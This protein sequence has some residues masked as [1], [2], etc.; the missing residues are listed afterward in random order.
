M[1][2]STRP[3][4]D[5]EPILDLI[6]TALGQE[7]LSGLCEMLEGIARV[8]DAYGCI[9]WQETPPTGPS[10]DHLFVL[11]HWF[12]DN[13]IFATHD[14]PIEG[15]ATGEAVRTSRTRN[16][17]DVHKGRIFWDRFMKETGIQAFCSIPIDFVDGA[18][19][20]VNLYRKEAQAFSASEIVQLERLAFLVPRLYQTILDRV[21]FN[22][23]SKVT[24]ISHAADLRV[25]R[26]ALLSRAE[27]HTTLRQICKQVSNAFQCIETSIFM[28]DRLETP[29]VYELVAT[30]WPSNLPFEKVT[31][32][33]KRTEGA[34]GW[35]L[36]KA[37]AVKLFDL[38]RFDAKSTGHEYPSLVWKDSLDIKSTVRML[39]HKRPSE[40]LPPLSFM[41]AP[42]LWGKT[43]FGVIRCSVARQGP[44]YFAERELNLLSL[45]AAQI[46]RYWHSWL[47]QREL[48][49]DLHSLEA[50]VQSMG[51][52]NSFVHKELTKPA[53][54]EQRI[55]REALKVTSNVIHGAEITDVRL[56][57]TE[58]RELYFATTQGRYWNS[59]RRNLRFP[60]N[61]DESSAGWYVMHTG[62]TYIVNNVKKDKF[63]HKTFANTKRL[64]VAP[65][66][67]GMERGEKP[68]PSGVLDIRSVIDRD[69]SGSAIHV[70]TLLGR[71]LALY[72]FLAQV[73]HDLRRS[74]AE[75]EMLKNQRIR[76]FQDMDHQFKSPITQAHARVQAL[77]KLVDDED[78]KQRLLA[79]R[80]LCAKAK[81]VS[82][83]SGL[84][85][86]LALEES[87]RAVK[88]QCKGSDLVK[89]LIEATQ[90]NRLMVSSR[91]QIGAH[92]EP[93]GIE[94]LN[95]IKL[96]KNLLEQAVTNVLDNAFKYSY[97]YTHVK[98]S[99]G[100]TKTG[101]FFILVENEGI[102]IL[103]GEQAL[104][105]LRGWQ[106]EAA[107]PF[108]DTGSGIGLWI[109]QHIMLAHGGDLIIEPT[110]NRKT[111]VRLVFPLE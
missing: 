82:M 67:L 8:S 18:R 51:E 6:A 64:I 104:C 12:Q 42:I 83:N 34:T 73:I 92:V 39:L 80:G 94:Y 40:E 89:L 16:V 105:I 32:R 22:L 84:F 98:V 87:I 99:G 10:R 37:K 70:A 27:M 59:E 107:I 69:F 14:I 79:V 88:E 15:S 102:P 3:S 4:I 53:P 106:S 1:E 103:A 36:E 101:R 46:G 29:G 71:Q 48:Q 13:S 56:L 17:E 52:L 95:S 19:G 33:R 97:P 2:V 55:L 91:R 57:D 7:E 30:T 100:L 20:A 49:L 108:S 41:A 109:V 24:E 35:V 60:M 77:L 9:L 31:Y 75:Q 86:S 43:V 96:D 90:D 23:I 65:L 76:V 62:E 85:A 5:G 25:S 61:D 78:V 44:F 81:R 111:E 50:L 68:E 110:R 63:Y 58:T 74:A 72:R 11:A 21:S 93:D 47:S 28:E 66:S 26:G 45:V 54:D 38:A